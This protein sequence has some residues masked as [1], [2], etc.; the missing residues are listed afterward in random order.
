M[1]SGTDDDVG[2]DLGECGED[3]LR[4]GDAGQEV[5]VRADRH[6]EE[7]LEHHSVHM[8]AGQHGHHLAGA[9]H[10]RLGHI[11]GSVHIGVKRPVGDH[12]ALGES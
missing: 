8:R 6:L 4:A 5:Y 12:H 11:F 7:E 1:T 3:D 10:L 9:V 2:P